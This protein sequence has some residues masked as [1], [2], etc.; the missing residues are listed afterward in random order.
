MYHSEPRF[1][2]DLDLW[3]EP[4]P[5]NAAR[6]REAMLKFG[7]W[8]SHMDVG[9]FSQPGVMFQIGVPPVR[10]DLL[11]SVPG[12]EF[13]GCW[14]RREAVRIGGIEVPFLGLDD[15]ILA[16]QRAGRDQDLLDLE[17]L[18]RRID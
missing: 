4:D 2:K 1:T 5:D 9:D 7:A 14:T 15:L 8:L 16:K 17:K 12:L 13:P 6:L 3:I 10:V 11:T 18:R